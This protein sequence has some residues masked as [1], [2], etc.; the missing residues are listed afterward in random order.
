M[1]T[2]DN[3]KQV[4]KYEFDYLILFVKRDNYSSKSR[5]LILNVHSTCCFTLIRVY[6]W[7]KIMQCNC[8]TASI[9]KP[10]ITVSLVKQKHLKHEFNFESG[11]P[12][13]AF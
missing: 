5:M 11:N 2:K 10:R 4:P 8:L 6:Y 9:I 12:D 3:N 7:Y 1:F 13:S